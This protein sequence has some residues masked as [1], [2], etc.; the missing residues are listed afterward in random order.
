LTVQTSG[1]AD[2]VGRNILVKEYSS[3]QGSNTTNHAM[4]LTKG[5]VEVQGE[6]YL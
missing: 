6:G 2:R 5:R 3:L 4:A 1:K